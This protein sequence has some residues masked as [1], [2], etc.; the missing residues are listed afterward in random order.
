MSKVIS[1]TL[2]LGSNIGDRIFNIN[3][4]IKI[5]SQKLLSNNDKMIV[6][7]VYESLPV[8]CPEDSLNFLNT[9][10]NVST[11]FKPQELIKI[12]QGIELKMG[13]KPK[14]QRLVNAPRIIDIDIL[15]YNSL[16]YNSENLTIPHP[17]LH[18]RLFV[19]APLN[20]IMP[21]YVVPNINKSV[22]SL[23]NSLKGKQSEMIE[24][25]SHLDINSN[26]Y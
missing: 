23:Y 25:F 16:V 7:P 6:A 18:E 22:S 15:F 10:I 26:R 24:H 17:R 20:D 12:T 8:D 13:R 21:N 4:A 11:N 2:S 3:E 5:I 9:V 19:L 14:N 1:V